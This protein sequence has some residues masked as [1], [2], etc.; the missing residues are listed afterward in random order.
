MGKLVCPLCGTATSVSP[1][2][3]EDD[4][5]FLP[6]QSSGSQSNYAKARVYAITDDNSPNYVSYGV[7]V[8]EACGERFVAKKHK[9]DDINWIAVYPIQHKTVDEEIPEPIKSEFA[10][11][12]L[13]FAIEAYIGCLL[14]CK[15]VLIALQREQ[16]VSN[17]I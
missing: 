8:C 16:G 15:T 17:L 12:N 6:D 1:V 14:V 4:R 2:I 9:Y 10:E 3:I 7:L 5:A 11:A 13:C